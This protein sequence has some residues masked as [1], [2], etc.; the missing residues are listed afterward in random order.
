MTAPDGTLVSLLDASYR[1]LA[2]ALEDAGP[3]RW[4]EP[5][6]C[7]GWTVAHAVATWPLGP[8]RTCPDDAAH[9]VLDALAASSPNLFGVDAA[10]RAWGASDLDRWQGIS[11]ASARPAGELV[12]LLAGRGPAAVTGVDALRP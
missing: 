1:A 12:L 6:L 5:S 10:L 2:D 11:D 3:D 9:L 8:G 7:E 4:S